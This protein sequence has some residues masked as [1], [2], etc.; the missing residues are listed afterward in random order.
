[1]PT[2]HDTFC[3]SSAFDLQFCGISPRA[4]AS[5]I[6]I[7]GNYRGTRERTNDE[8]TSSLN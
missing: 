5:V 6:Q 7:K 8:E 1:M 2:G 4:S 3:G